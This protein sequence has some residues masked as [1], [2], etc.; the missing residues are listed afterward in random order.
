[1]DKREPRK[2]RQQK[3]GGRTNAKSFTKTNFFFFNFLTKLSRFVPIV[4]GM[5]EQKN[6]VP[7]IFSVC[8]PFNRSVVAISS[9]SVIHWFYL[10]MEEPGRNTGATM[11][12]HG[13]YP[14]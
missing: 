1:M 12:Y 9:S 10:K 2:R 5:S 6:T 3:G 7:F 4:Y 11:T 13:L 14:I 8:M